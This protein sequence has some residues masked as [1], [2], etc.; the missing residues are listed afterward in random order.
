MRSICLLVISLLI[1][2][3]PAR[4]A[5][6]TQETSKVQFAGMLGHVVNFFGGKAAREGVTDTVAVKANRKRTTSD[7]TGQIIDLD[8]EKIYDLDLHGKSY[9]VTTFEEMRRKMQEARER[10]SKEA[11]PQKTEQPNEPAKQMQIDFDL[12]ES[13]EKK[14]ING[15]DCREVVMT[16]SIHEKDKP[17]EQSG[18]MVLTA[19]DWLGPKVDAMKDIADFDRRY[20]EKLAGPFAFAAT[21]ADAEQM[22]AAMAAYPQ[23]KDALGK[24]QVENVKMD[25][26]PILMTMTMEAVSTPEQ[27]AQQG[28][29]DN[30]KKDTNLNITSVR[31]MLG[32]LGKKIAERKAD[33]KKSE[34][35]NTPGRVS[36]MTMNHEVKS[37]STDVAESDLAIPAGFKEK[38]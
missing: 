27:M 10:G 31:G 1:T 35:A 12:K 13:G 34:T 15:F 24:F 8:E 14:N 18:G 26:T 9:R 3:S 22:A 23:M 17:I 5:V 37:I 36:F 11:P 2:C 30:E 16:I 32:G 6:K 28:K 20:E 7:T 38:K 21:P 25:G 29:Q 19:H 4:A 33:Q